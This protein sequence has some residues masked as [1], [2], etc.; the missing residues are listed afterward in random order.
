[1]TS[2]LNQKFLFETSYYNFLLTC[3][4][5]VK[6]RKLDCVFKAIKN[7]QKINLI[8]RIERNVNNTNLNANGETFL[9]TK[10]KVF[11]VKHINNHI[12]SREFIK[13]DIEIFVDNIVTLFE[14]NTTTNEY[15]NV[16]NE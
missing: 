11:K 7:I 15:V 3:V 2:V 8:F 5:I 10:S 9:F 4:G 12:K 13:H 1:M 14:N 6:I 16:L